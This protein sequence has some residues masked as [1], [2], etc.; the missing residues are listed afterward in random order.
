MTPESKRWQR[1]ETVIL[2]NDGQNDVV[3]FVDQVTRGGLATLVGSPAKF[4]RSGRAVNRSR[5]WCPRIRR[6]KDDAETEAVLAAMETRRLR[7]V[8]TSAFHRVGADKL[9][10]DQCRVI[11]KMLGVDHG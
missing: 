6:P 7:S 1:G 8:L 2:N 5:F 4:D 9:S 11:L 3:I 10:A